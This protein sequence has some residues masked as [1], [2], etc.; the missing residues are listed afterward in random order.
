MVRSWI[1]FHDSHLDAIAT[2]G[3]DVSIHLRAFVH[4]WERRDGTWVGTGWVQPATIT[5]SNP[6]MPVPA[7]ETS[8]DVWNGSVRVDETVHDNLAPLPFEA[9]GSVQVLME[10]VTGVVVEIS[11]DQV[12]L[13]A[14]GDARFV[15]DL[16]ADLLPPDLK[17]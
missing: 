15:E 13:A 4:R 11:G 9:T 17:T 5:V 7:I 6:T 2:S 10:L 1:E 8:V 16:L 12:T 14:T 3:N